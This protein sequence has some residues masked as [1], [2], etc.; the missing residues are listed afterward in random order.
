MFM[1]GLSDG[2]GSTWLNIKRPELLRFCHVCFPGLT[3]F[4]P[5]FRSSDHQ[6]RTGAPIWDSEN[7]AQ[8]KVSHR[9]LK[10]A[11]TKK[12]DDGWNVC[13]QSIST[14]AYSTMNSKRSTWGPR[15]LGETYKWNYESKIYLKEFT[16]LS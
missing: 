15:K 8:L 9:P 7:G 10:T 12:P 14:T 6:W 1:D 16:N 3:W 5:N 13:I 2:A 11:S 4:L